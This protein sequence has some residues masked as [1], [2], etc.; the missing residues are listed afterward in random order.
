DEN[1]NKVITFTDLVGRLQQKH[2]QVNATEWLR[3]L[4]IYET[5]GPLKYTFQPE[6]MRQLGTAT[7][8]STTLLNQYAFKYTYDAIGRLAEKVVPGAAPVYFCYDPLDRVTLVQDGNL[9]GLNK[10]MFIK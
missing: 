10:W 4:Y 1:G 7:T 2:V 8:I 5:W 3:T 6:G 9:R